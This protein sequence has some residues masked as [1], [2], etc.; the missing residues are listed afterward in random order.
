MVFTLAGSQ[1]GLSSR[2][3]RSA[4]G[5]TSPSST[6]I[7]RWGTHGGTPRPLPRARSASEQSG[8]RPAA[9]AIPSSEHPDPRPMCRGLRRGRRPRGGAARRWEAM[10]H[11]PAS[12]RPPSPA[13]PARIV[14]S[15]EPAPSPAP[16]SAPGNAPG[17]APSPAAAGAS[18]RCAPAASQ[19]CA[20]GMRRGWRGCAPQPGML[21]GWWR[22]V[23]R[24]WGCSWFGGAWPAAGVWDR[25]WKNGRMEVS[26][27]VWGRKVRVGFW[28]GC[29]TWGVLQGVLLAWFGVWGGSGG[30]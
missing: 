15:A 5:S 12:L 9:P 11:R 14:S 16:G 22:D 29:S 3:S 30:R 24:S 25:G 6:A 7:P 8:Q 2:T 18:P 26:A 23:S 28:G 10:S 19:P 13:A 21:R 17:S 20:P 1:P 27:W 4:P